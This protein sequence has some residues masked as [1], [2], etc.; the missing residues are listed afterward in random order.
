MSL[1]TSA[2]SACNVTG[3]T[4]ETLCNCNVCD[5]NPV[6]KG[7]DRK[8]VHYSNSQN[9]PQ[10]WIN[11]ARN[12][13]FHLHK[14][15]YQSDNLCPCPVLGKERDPVSFGGFHSRSS[16][17]WQV[18][19]LCLGCCF[20]SFCRKGLAV[21]FLFRYFLLVF[22]TFIPCP[23]SLFLFF[24]PPPVP[25]GFAPVAASFQFEW[26]ARHGLWALGSDDFT[27]ITAHSPD[28]NRFARPIHKGMPLYLVAVATHFNSL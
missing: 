8:N 25:S 2:S 9:S 18:E 16:G 1:A 10:K 13:R 7:G 4:K 17:S 23:L 5:I 14:C 19:L 3:V 20:V 12:I 24:Y 27:T 28:G 15:S 21:F 11:K 26:V 6:R 22:L